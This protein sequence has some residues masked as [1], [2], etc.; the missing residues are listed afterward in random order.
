MV[1]QSTA[2]AYGGS[3]DLRSCEH[4]KPRF[5]L[6]NTM[7]DFHRW[8]RQDLEPSQIGPHVSEHEVDDLKAMIQKQDGEW[9]PP[10]FT[11]CDLSPFNIMVRGEQIV[12]LID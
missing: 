10:D 12:G 6:L 5:G 1:P 11:H 3:T 2:P 4:G 7:E 9:P 8:L